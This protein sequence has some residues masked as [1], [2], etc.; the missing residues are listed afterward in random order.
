MRRRRDLG[1]L[2]DEFFRDFFEDVFE[3]LRPRR[4]RRLNPLMEE[5]YEDYREPMHDVIETDNEVIVTVEIPGV[6]KEDIDINVS[7]RS[8]EI[9]AE[10]KEEEKKEG[11]EYTYMK[12]YKGFYKVIPLPVEVNTEKVKA[13]YNNGV[14]EVRLEKK[15]KEEK[16]KVK[17]E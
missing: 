12:E 15:H 9:K 3:D 5:E 11:E 13:T 16:K 10:H 1:D 2:F 7:S 8:I 6:K 4:G 17:V 14:L